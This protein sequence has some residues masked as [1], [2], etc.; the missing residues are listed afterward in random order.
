MRSTPNGYP[1][2][3]FNADIK[4]VCRGACCVVIFPK[5]VGAGAD[6]EDIPE[7]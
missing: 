4:N 6:V 7:K 3:V 5:E 1:L 2:G